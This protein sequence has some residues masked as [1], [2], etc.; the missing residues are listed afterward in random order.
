MRMLVLAPLALFSVG[1]AAQPNDT[2]RTGDAAHKCPPPTVTAAAPKPG[3]FPLRKLGEEP[4]AAHIAAV[5]GVVDGCPVML[6]LDEGGT[7]AG[8]GWSP[9]PEGALH[10]A[11]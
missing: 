2:V 3:K 6:V 5:H 11:E 7:G 4:P 9:V 1:A 10:P 8:Q